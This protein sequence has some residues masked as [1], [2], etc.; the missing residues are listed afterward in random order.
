MNPLPDRV[1]DD[2]NRVQQRMIQAQTSPLPDGGNTP[3]S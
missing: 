3:R 2:L 1:L